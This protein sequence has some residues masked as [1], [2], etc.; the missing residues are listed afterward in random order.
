MAGIGT[1]HESGLH[2]GLKAWYARPGDEA[3]V[4]LD[5]CVADL[6][7]G[8]LVV[9]IQTHHF[10][11]IKRK[12]L[13]LVE[14]R[15]VRLVYPIA[16]ERWIVRVEADRQT[17][18]GRRKSPRRGQA[19]H[20]FD[21]LTSFPE[22]IGHPNFS[23]EVLLTR[24]EEVRCPWSGPRRGRWKREWQVCD[25]RLLEVASSLVLASPADCLALLPS[26]LPRPFSN[27]HLARALRQPPRLAARMTYCLR[28]MGA[29]A[30]LGKA[31]RALIYDYA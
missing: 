3:E 13:R 20:V 4:K 28:R 18:V 23:L 8:D 1:L 16:L 22:L 26:G 6:V 25:R 15:P 31:G 14:T 30:E 12:L 2:S 29:I 17:V 11:A 24:E 9:E 7:R 5:G 21:E 10:Y 27:S 19:A